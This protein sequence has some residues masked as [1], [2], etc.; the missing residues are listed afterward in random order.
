MTNRIAISLLASSL[1]AGTALATPPA[2]VHPV[3]VSAP[4]AD[5]PPKEVAVL[6]DLAAVKIVAITLRE[7]TTLPDH[8][9][10]VPVTIEATHGTASLTVGD[11]TTAL[12]PGSF[13]VLDAHTTHAVTPTD[14]SP[15]TV[16]VHHHKGGAQ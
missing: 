8:T 7:G 1:T 15:V 12:K 14:A 4:A 11:T 3:T 10:A 9:A 6:A 16:L 5:G 13:V 2:R